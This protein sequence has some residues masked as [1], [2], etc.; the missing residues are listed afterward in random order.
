MDVIL[1]WLPTLI[2]VGVF[3][4]SAIK[5]PSERGSLNGGTVKAYAEAA[6]L[7]GEDAKAAREEARAAKEELRA[8]EGRVS[9]IERKRYQCYMEFDIGD[10]PTVGVV[11]IQ[12]VVPEIPPTP[13][14]PNKRKANN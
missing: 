7:A 2:A 13:T 12:P 8:L 1:Q 6:Q 14:K 3:I 5:S 11:K 10:P 9:V 4:L